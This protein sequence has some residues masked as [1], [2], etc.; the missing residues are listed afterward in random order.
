[1]GALFGSLTSVFIGLSDLFL[2][3]TTRRAHT[4]TVTILAFVSAAATSVVGI[5]VLDG[6]QIGRDIGIG[7]GGG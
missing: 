1:M 5:L 4:I 2:V 6:E 7:V 3:T